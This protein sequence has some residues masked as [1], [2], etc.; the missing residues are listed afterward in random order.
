MHPYK[1]ALVASTALLAST[2]LSSANVTSVTE[3]FSAKTDWGTNPKTSG[4]APSQTIGFA[5]FNSGLGTLTKV[6]I[7]L[8]NS[9]NGSV[10]LENTNPTVPTNVTASLLNTL[11]YTYPT[12]SQQKKLLP[13][14]SFTDKTLAGGASTGFHSVSGSTH[15]TNVITTSLGAFE[16]AWHVTAGDFGQVIISSGNGNGSATYTD[17][18]SVK[19]VAEYSFT[20]KTSSPP[21]V[22]EPASMTLLG[23][24]LAGL[25][26]L[27]RRRKST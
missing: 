8:T 12:I 23:A 13:S 7:V 15:S 4:F 6:M 10:D 19:V 25:G 14:D 2:T 16:A 1:L 26:L 17:V 21:G 24:G 9:V 20:P 22:P 27:R 5:A 11:K 3:S 18:G